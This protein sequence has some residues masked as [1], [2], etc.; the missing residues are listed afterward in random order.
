MKN[1]FYI[2]TPIYYPSAKLHIGHAYCTTLCDV[3]ARFRRMQGYETYF[4]TGA[5]EHGQKIEKNAQIAGKTPQEFVDGIVVGFH[6]LWSALEI[7]NDDFIRTTEKRHYE[8][9]QRIFSRMIA[10]DDIYLSKYE[11]WY[12]TH[13]EAFW[14][15]TQVGP[16]HLCPDCGR[17]VARDSEPAYFFRTGK[18]LDRLLKF[19]DENPKFITPESRKNEMIN[20]FIK[21]GLEDLSVS[22]TS[23]KWGIPV[24]ENPD[25]VVYVWLD[26]LTNYITALGYDSDNDGLFKKF[27]ADENTEIIHVIGADITRFHTIYWPMFLM[28]EGLRLPDREFV[29]GLLMMKDGKMSKSKGNVVDPYPLLER[30]GVDALRYYLVRETTFGSDGQFTPEQFVERIN[31][32]LANDFGNLLNRTIAMIIKY[33][34][35][36]VPEYKGDVTP[37]DKD[38]RELAEF[39]V[40]DYETLLADLKITDA[41]VSVFKLISAANKYIDNTEPW[42]LKKNGEDKQLASVMNHLANV[43]YEAGI[44]LQPVLTHAPKKLFDALGVSEEKRKYEHIRTF[45]V[46][47]GEE[48]K[49]IDPL[50]PRLDVEVE[51]NFIKDLM[52]N[53]K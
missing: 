9:V 27:W 37:F 49:K 25:H 30:Y 22:R 50:F 24:L 42:N 7:T 8:V 48:V 6:K 38:L 41:F 28:S 21:P 5:D 51:V 46:L 39:T 15:D 43:L 16:N 2:T 36:V 40:K 17:P 52:T 11:G 35:G 47:G 19:Y 3:Y 33:F 10:R 12:C 34:D 13:C 53:K 26:A 29:H 20:T 32:D 31:V 23:F 4:L 18:Y 45:G 44:L 14:T 1:K